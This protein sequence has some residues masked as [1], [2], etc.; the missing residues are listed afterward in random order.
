M[1]W[2]GWKN[3]EE[4]M[5]VPFAFV[6]NLDIAKS[7][8]LAELSHTVTLKLK[9]KRRLLYRDGPGHLFESF[10]NSLQ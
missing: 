8:K 7:K 9:G 5:E 3:L 2:N 6:L 10:D 1:R 4:G